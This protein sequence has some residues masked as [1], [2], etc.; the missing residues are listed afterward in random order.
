MIA[1]TLLV[2]T[3]SGCLDGNRKESAK[4]R[5]E[6]TM[7]KARIQAAQQSFEEGRLVY[8]ERILEDC[9]RCSDPQ[10][11]LS[12][13]A[14]QILAKVHYENE[15]YAKAGHHITSIDDMIY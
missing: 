11:P 10:S 4:L 8:A 5:W 15:Q 12:R 9:Q 13:Q 3:V 2:M 14:Q 6:R 7:D 1:A